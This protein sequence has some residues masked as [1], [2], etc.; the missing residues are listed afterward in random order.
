MGLVLRETPFGSDPRSG[1]R[2]L[3]RIDDPF[4]RLWF[5]VVAPGRTALAQ[6]PRETR[7]EYWRRHRAGLEAQAW[8]ELCRMAVPFLHRSASPLAD[9]GPW[10]PAQRYWRRNEPEFDVVARSVDGRRLLIGEAKAAARSLPGA[11][12]RFRPSAPRI[13]GLGD[14]EIVPVVF[15]PLG[16]AESIN[17]GGVH[18]V[19]ARVVFGLLR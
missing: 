17:E 2:S 9:L 4:L 12:L 15:A 11:S 10:E 5:R 3:Y 14:L 19:D 13:A 1:K 16:T 7:L 18:V 8:E 6:A